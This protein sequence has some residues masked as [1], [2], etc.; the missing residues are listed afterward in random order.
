MATKTKIMQTRS[1]RL[2]F[3]LLLLLSLLTACDNKKVY[4]QFNHA[5][6]TGWEKTDSLIFCIPK[7]QEAGDYSLQL[8]MRADN[9]YPFM[10]VVLIVDQT[11]LPEKQVYSDTIN[12]RLTDKYGNTLGKGINLYQFEFNVSDRRLNKDDSL[13]VTVRHDMKREILPG[14]ADIGIALSKH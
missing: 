6:I 5:P 1:N 10:S 12:C 8:K 11:V 3:L 14:I 4:D 7:L 13:Y 9:S 2:F